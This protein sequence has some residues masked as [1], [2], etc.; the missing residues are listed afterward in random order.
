[1]TEQMFLK[2]QW[3]HWELITSLRKEGFVR[4]SREFIG[5]WCR[6]LKSKLRARSGTKNVEESPQ[7]KRMEHSWPVHCDAKNLR[8]F[9]KYLGIWK[10]NFAWVTVCNLTHQK[11]QNSIR[12][13][14]S[15]FSGFHLKKKEQRI[16]FNLAFFFCQRI[17]KE[18]GFSNMVRSLLFPVA[19]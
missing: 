10:E 15:L 2:K 6:S 19:S 4:L 13:P 14:G 8:K 1:M 18:T 5:I 9:K 3:T 12:T 16:D 11:M 7:I 17:A